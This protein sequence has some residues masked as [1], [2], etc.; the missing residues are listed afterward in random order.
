[1]GEGDYLLQFTEGEQRSDS[2]KVI[3]WVKSKAT[4][5]P[6]FLPPSITLTDTQV[7]VFHS[8]QVRQHGLNVSFR[9]YSGSG[10]R[11][12]YWSLQI[13]LQFVSLSLAVFNGSLT[14]SMALQ[15]GGCSERQKDIFHS[16]EVEKRVLTTHQHIWG[17]STSAT[18][19]L[20]SGSTQ[21]SH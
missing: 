18:A 21:P 2:L 16:F 7:T 3:Q 12:D 13:K 11:D 14:W 19:W 10:M 9:M 15:G 4:D 8:V 5:L 20:T 17:P 6:Q 1:M